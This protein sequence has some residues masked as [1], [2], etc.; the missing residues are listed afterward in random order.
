VARILLDTGPL[1][2][3]FKRNDASHRRAAEWFARNRADLVTTHA[4]L[5]EAW[6]LINPS[7]RAKLMAFTNE[8][9]VVPEL[10]DDAISRLTRLLA[11]YA[12]TPMDYADATL[13]L[14]A[15]ELGELRVATMDI[16]D[17]AAYRTEGK[18]A[19]RVVF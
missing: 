10:P 7:A 15:H 6:H 4:V 12:D 16:G 2:A 3:L 19:L 18:K 11:T 1:V 8:A 13:V 5:T 9:L 14:L 17:F